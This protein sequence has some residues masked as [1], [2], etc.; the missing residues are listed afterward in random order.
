MV[1]G[2]SMFN[3]IWK[4][5]S[6]ANSY[7]KLLQVAGRRDSLS[8]NKA[9]ANLCREAANVLRNPANVSGN[10]VPFLTSAMMNLMAQVGLPMKMFCNNDL[11]LPPH[12]PQ[13]HSFPPSLP[14]GWLSSNPF[15]LEVAGGTV[16]TTSCA[17]IFLPL[18]SKTDSSK[19]DEV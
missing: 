11:L 4:Q 7:W 3:I 12:Q 18:N 14:E 13:T 9:S 17:T 16:L 5:R 1:V 19:L 2:R 8:Q 10:D 15:H 6:L